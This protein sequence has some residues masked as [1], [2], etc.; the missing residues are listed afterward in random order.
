M[1]RFYWHLL[2]IH[3]TQPGP[4]FRNIMR[5]LWR[6]LVTIGLSAPKTCNTSM[7]ILE[8]QFIMWLLY[9]IED[10]TKL[11]QG[12]PAAHMV[13]G[14]PL[15]VQ[16]T[17]H[18]A[19][20]L[21]Q[22]MIY[23]LGDK[24]LVGGFIRVG[25]NLMTGQ[26][27][28]IYY[29]DTETCPTFDDSRVV[30]HGKSSCTFMWGVRLLEMFAKTKK[31]NFSHEFLDKMGYFIQVYDD[32]INLHNPKWATVRIFCDDL[33]EEKFRY[34]IIHA[35]QSHPEDH[36]LIN[37]LKKRP[38]DLESKKLFV[39]IMES[40]G[41]FEHS[42]EFLEDLK[43]GILEEVKKMELERNPH[44]ERVLDDIFNNLETKLFIDGCD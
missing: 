17:I 20:L 21:F 28:E 19:I 10:L 3:V 37:L 35:I 39:D 16:A 34:P 38:L 24:P 26:G 27:V 29:R 15:T 30:V 14:V 11:R 23:H 33:D 32:Y 13:Y 43:Y 25:L 2:S 36:R 5:R 1:K 18:K 8:I 9:E 4:E 44:L 7:V 6:V 12:I 22:N 40:F 31:I 41:S 42:R